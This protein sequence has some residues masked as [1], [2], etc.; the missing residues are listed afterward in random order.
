MWRSAEF[1]CIHQ[2]PKLFLGL[3]RREAKMFKHQGLQGPVVD[4]DR[5]TT[6]F[7]TIYYHIVRI[8]SY[9]TWFSI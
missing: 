2:K 9:F 8:C 3:F 4:T 1:K 6:D 7:C 5:T